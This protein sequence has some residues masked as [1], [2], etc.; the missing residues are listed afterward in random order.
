MNLKLNQHICIL[1]VNGFIGSNLA[2]AL[3][4][5][6]HLITGIDLH[7]FRLEQVS[8]L[9][10]FRFV[11]HDFRAF[12]ANTKMHIR[13]CDLV[14]PLVA[15][16][17]PKTYVTDPISVFELDFEAN[18]PYI[19]FCADQGIRLLFPS[20]SE[21]YGLTAEEVF[22]EKTTTLA[23][24]P[25]Q[26][27]RWIYACCK[28]LLDRIIYALGLRN[29]LNY[30]IFRPFNWLGPGLDK[31]SN[32]EGTSRLVTQLL[33]D[34][35]HKNQLTL[36]DGGGQSRSF[37]DIRD[38][39]DAL[40]K[41]IEQPTITNKKIYNIGNPENECSVK[42]FAQLLLEALHAQFNWFDVASVNIIER[43]GADYY[44]TGYQDVMRRVPS[45]SSISADLNWMPGYSN[46]DSLSNIVR[47]LDQAAVECLRANRR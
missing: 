22:E 47:C 32:E 20:T 28:Q 44:G 30:T 43:A 17:T 46:R 26:N 1:G 10:N 7:D 8:R 29:E 14:V 25:I 42:E 37:T 18:L 34:I 6:G 3:L 31:L 41:I 23:Y 36:V 40:V 27:E 2:I 16:A 38:G 9:E 39:I 5:R 15:I 11:R 45:I 13:K 12:N 19:R 4:S 21:V 33:S 24:G 35:I